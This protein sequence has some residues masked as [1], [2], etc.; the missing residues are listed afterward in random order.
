MSTIDDTSE[1]EDF[2]PGMKIRILEG[3]FKDFRGKIKEVDQAQEQVIA[4]INF[5]GREVK[6]ELNFSQITQHG[7]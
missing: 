5:F 1:N 3:P 6:A 2:K 7:V 4:A